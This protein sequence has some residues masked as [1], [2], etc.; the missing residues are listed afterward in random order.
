MKDLTIRWIGQNGYLL[1]DGETEICIDP[2]LSNVVDRVSG[3]GRMVEAPIDPA[4]LASDAVICTHNHLDH[5]DIDAIPLMPKEK[6]LFLAPTHAEK[7][8]VEC[9][10]THFLPFDEG[11]SYEVGDF[12]LTAVFADHSVPAVG[13]IVEHAGV[14][15]YFSGDTEYHEK[16]TALA[17]RRIDIMF[18]CINGKLGNMNVNEAVKLT[19]ILSPRV[20]VPTHYGMFESNTEDPAKYLSRVAHGFE[21]KH[22]VSYSVGEV[23][24]DV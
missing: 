10:V 4:K 17:E 22:N 3:R 20:G 24:A 15:L 18:I 5:V 21:M 14:T 1:S 7:T 8:L 13:V 16:L 2:Y 19:E 12:R 9:G 6:M 11:A 23:L